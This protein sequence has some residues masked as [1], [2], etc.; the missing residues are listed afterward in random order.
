MKNSCI[1]IIL[2]L[3]IGPLTLSAP[4]FAH[5]TEDHGKTSSPDAQMKKLHAMMPMFSITTATLETALDK[6]DANAAE[7]EAGKIVAA[8]PD[9]KKSKPHKNT[10]QKKK[11][12]AMATRLETAVNTT[13]K[14]A[15]MGDY[16]GARRSFNKLEEAC[17]A[18]HAI[19]RD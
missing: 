3:L 11:F 14:L 8:L 4:A 1:I 18:C 15:K 5:G 16:A 9:L 7:V 17:A 19:F 12:M 13:V 10:N 2:G 6:G